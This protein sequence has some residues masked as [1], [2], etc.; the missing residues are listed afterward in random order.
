MFI[1]KFGTFDI[2]VI[3]ERISN[4]VMLDFGTLIQ[5]GVV[6][7]WANNN[8]VQLGYNLLKWSGFEV[9]DQIVW[10]MT[11]EDDQLSHEPGNLMLTSS[12]MC[13][14]AAKNTSG[15]YLEYKTKVSNNLIFSPKGSTRPKEIY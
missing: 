7:V 5:D 15:K 4:L 2:A 13:L 10:V 9:I 8:E 12:C 6:F 11:D 3:D 1:Q 14:V